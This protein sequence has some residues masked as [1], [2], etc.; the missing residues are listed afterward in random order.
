MW[1]DDFFMV[2]EAWGQGTERNAYYDNGFDAMINFT[3]QGNNG[4]NGPV[5]KPETMANVF[6]TYAEKLRTQNMNVLTYISSH[7]TYLFNRK[8][9][10][11][12][13]TYQLLLPGAIEVFYGDETGRPYSTGSSDPIMGTRSFMNWDSIDESILAHFS[14]IAG[15]RRRNLAVGAGTH[16]EISNAPLT[17]VR[18]LEV[19][20]TRNTVMVVLGQ[21]TPTEL[22][23][24]KAFPDQATVRDAYTMAAYTVKYGRI[25]LR[26]DEEGIVLLE[27]L[28]Q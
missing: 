21:T 16:L 18:Q 9:L 26:P 3:F 24:S 8:Q 28:T 1:T 20:G 4:Y 12:A 13:L 17:F 7:D 23:V 19:S 10:K 22:D 25:S 27:E 2:G 11:S 14:K 5:Y 6:K 15:F